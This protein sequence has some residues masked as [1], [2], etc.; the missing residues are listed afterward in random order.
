MDTEGKQE[1]AEIVNLNLDDI[2]IEE[3]EQ[4]I[5]LA[6]VDLKTMFDLMANCGTFARCLSFTGMCSTFGPCTTF[7][8]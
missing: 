7:T 5:E 4:R 3:L 2:D 6:A 1:R 8:E